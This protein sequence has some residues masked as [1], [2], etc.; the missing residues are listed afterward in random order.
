MDSLL[1]Y[2]QDLGEIFLFLYLNGKYY[3]LYKQSYSEYQVV[4]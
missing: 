4:F 2:N 1:S 3:V